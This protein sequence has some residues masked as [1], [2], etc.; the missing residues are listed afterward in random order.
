MCGSAWLFRR[1][2]PLVVDHIREEL[3]QMAGPIPVADCQVDRLPLLLVFVNGGGHGV[4]F[5][6]TIDFT[7]TA[8]VINNRGSQLFDADGVRY[9]FWNLCYNIVRIKTFKA[10]LSVFYV[11]FNRNGTSANETKNT[12]M[13]KNQDWFG[14]LYKIS[15]GR[16][17]REYCTCNVIF[18]TS[19]W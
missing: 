10:C 13:A 15:T 2:A 19:R 12:S 14:V 16:K 17:C 8:Q 5:S 6:Q 11:T 7:H 1:P 3:A 4:R 9:V 18:S